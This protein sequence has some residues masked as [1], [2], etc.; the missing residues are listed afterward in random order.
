MTEINIMA[1]QRV[2]ILDLQNDRLYF[3]S[4]GE[5]PTIVHNSQNLRALPE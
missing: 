5:K 1:Q 2:N 4:P 3:F